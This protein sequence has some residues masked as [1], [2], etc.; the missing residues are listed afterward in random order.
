[1]SDQIKTVSVSECPV[2]GSSRREGVCTS[3]FR[4]VK[5]IQTL[6]RYVRCLQC[7]G[8]YQSRCPV[9]EEI[10]R[11]Y[12]NNYQPY[13][14]PAAQPVEGTP[15]ASPVRPP[16]TAFRVARGF[17]RRVIRRFNN[18]LRHRRPYELPAA[19]QKFYTP[20]RP[21]QVLLDYG[22][23][24]P[25]FLDQAKAWGWD[26][27]GADFVPEV[28]ENVKASGHKGLLIAPDAIPD[29]PDG[30]VDALR[31]NHVIEHSYRPAEMLTRLRAKMKPGTAVHLATPNANALSFRLLGNRWWGLECPRHLVLL[32]PRS[33][34]FLLRK[35]GFTDIRLHQEL[36]TK[37][38]ARSLGFTLEDLGVLNRQEALDL[39]TRENLAQILFGPAW[40]AAR[41]GLADR[42]HAIA[43]AS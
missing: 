29:I 23:G 35:A 16:S 5:E 36:L 24:A 40:V 22:C 37:D 30:S 43:R 38:M 1:M 3:R 32:T 41:L 6:F 7:G 10:H 20:A 12:P 15:T 13:Q 28:V 2:C 8:C 14:L 26:T 21:G 4:E 19:L 39:P 18:M 33:M 27:I 9:P 31:L 11:C 17:A 42:I 25:V 34:R